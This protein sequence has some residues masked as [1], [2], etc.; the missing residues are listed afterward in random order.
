MGNQVRSGARLTGL[1]RMDYLVHPP[2]FLARYR[3]WW[4]LERVTLVVEVDFAV[5]LLRICSYASQFLPSP[6]Y[7]L[8]RVR[9]VLLSDIRSA[10]DEVADSLA[11][12]SSAVDGRG[13]LVRV[14]HLVFFGLRCQMEGRGD[15]FWDALSRAIRIAQSVGIH[16]EA[17]N[18]RPGVDEIEKEMGRRTF[19]NLYVLDSLLSRQLDRIPFLPGCLN[20]GNWPQMNLGTLGDGNGTEPAGDAPEPFTERLLQAR[21]ADFWRRV[22]PTAAADV[23]VAEERYELFCREYLAEL[24]PAFALQPNR[25]W[26]K[27]LPKLPLQRQLLHIAIYDSLCWNFRPFLLRLSHEPNL[28]AYKRMLLYSQKQALVVA[29]LH[30]L[31]GVSKLH[32]MLGGCHTRF[33]GLVFSTFEAAVLLVYL[34]MDPLLPT[35]DPPADGSSVSKSSKVPDPLRAADMRN[36][37]RQGCIEAVQGAL[38][39]LRMLAEVSNMADVGASILTQLLSKVS[40]ITTTTASTTRK[41]EIPQ[42]QNQQTAGDMASCFSFSPTGA[43]L[44]DDLMSKGD[45]STAVD[46]MM[47]W[48]SFDASEYDSQDNLMS[49]GAMQG[50]QNSWVMPIAGSN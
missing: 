41:E 17:A 12:I 15:A 27:H 5:L 42:D 38:D 14:Q 30:V 13:S 18:A 48:P 20:P 22:G 33:A 24:P 45:L 44:R 7:T 19:C 35:D 23:M 26:D 49:M 21:L 31:D 40:T 46:D 25:A 36:I 39:R 2:R 6:S 1:G 10:C 47:S 4:A 16:S 9:G 37:A 34:C 50:S 43:N 29:A 28:P 32:A 8:D 3:S 11:A